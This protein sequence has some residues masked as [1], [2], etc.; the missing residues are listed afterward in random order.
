P[1]RSRRLKKTQRTQGKVDIGSAAEQC[2]SQ[3]VRRLGVERKEQRPDESLVA[4]FHLPIQNCPKNE[5]RICSTSTATINYPTARNASLRSTA[6]YSGDSVLPTA[7]RARSHDSNA[8]R[9]QSRCRV[10]IA[11]LLSGLRFCLVIRARIFFCNCGRPSPVTQEI[12]RARKFFQ[13]LFSGRS[14]LFKTTI[15]FASPARSSKCGG[16]GGL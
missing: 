15:S 10:L 5:S 8:R 4:I 7:A 13:S 6:T 9:R 3:M 12:L 1:L 14:L 16:R 2:D 11:T